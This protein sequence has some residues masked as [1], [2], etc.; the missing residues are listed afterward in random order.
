MI[1]TRPV[2]KGSAELR[3]KGMAELAVLRATRKTRR[4]VT[5]DFKK[6][7]YGTAAIR[8]KLWKLQ[9]E[10][11]CYCERYYERKHADVEHFRPKTEAVRSAGT[12]PDEGY[13]WLAYDI[14]NL[15]FACPNCNRPKNTNF[16]LEKAPPLAPEDHPRVVK[17]WPTL[18]EPR[19]DPVEDH[20]TFERLPN[21][22]LQIAPRHG[23][24]RGAETIRI[25]GLDRDDLT[26]L[27]NKHYRMHLQSVIRRFR[28][29]DHATVRARVVSDA[30]KLAAAYA[31]YALLA[32]VLFRA[33]NIPI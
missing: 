16:P 10:K 15:Y 20:L 32:R 19:H 6:T 24:N 25:L 11:C 27:R 21:G 17:E 22:K 13:W 26:S 23:S 30:K 3:K 33:A 28:S 29:P 2:K 31:E 14:D 7:V 1:G 18:L 9:Y 12:G 8:T 5:G 4:L